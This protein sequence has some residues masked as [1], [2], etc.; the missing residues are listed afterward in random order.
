MDLAFGFGFVFM[1]TIFIDG[2]A[3]VCL[4][5]FLNFFVFH[6]FWG[7][8]HRLCYVRSGVVFSGNSLLDCG[9]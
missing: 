3:I 9:N 5:F 8:I 4:F 2:N 1:G 6:F 7:D